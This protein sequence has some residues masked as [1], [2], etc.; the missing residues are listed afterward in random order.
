MNYTC[1]EVLNRDLGGNMNYSKTMNQTD[2]L[3]TLKVL[4]YVRYVKRGLLENTG[5]AHSVRDR[6]TKPHP[7]PN[8]KKTITHVLADGTGK[9]E[10]MIIWYVTERT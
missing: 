9:D 1:P 8:V 7:D 4:N 3:F 2:P 10:A 6:F 5:Q